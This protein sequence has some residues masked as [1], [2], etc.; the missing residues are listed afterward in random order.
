MNPA[1]LSWRADAGLAIAVD[2]RLGR[3]RA[4]DRSRAGGCERVRRAGAIGRTLRALG[5]IREPGPALEAFEAAVE[6]L[7]E[8]QAALE[9][10]GGLVD[11][12]AALRRSGMRRDAREPLREGLELAERCGAQALAARARREVNAAGARPRRAAL[13]GQEA[14]TTRERQVAILAAEG[15][16]NREIAEQLV[17]TVK[18]VEWHLKNSFQKLGITSRTQLRDKLGG[19]AEG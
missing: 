3:G 7:R 12:G 6:A 9:R 19:D 13:S 11:F 4:A 14:L 15:L 18:T 2:R 10:A 8:S 17:V 16:S 1:V 5:S